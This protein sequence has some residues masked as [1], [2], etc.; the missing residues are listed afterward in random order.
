MQ[1][2][3]RA[4]RQLA[5]AQRANWSLRGV[6]QPSRSES[7]GR[8]AAVA[9]CQPTVAR[10]QPTVAR[11]ANW[12]SHNE[13]IGRCAVP[14]GRRAAL[15]STGRHA[16]HQLVVALCQPTVA[17]RANW[18]SHSESIGRCTVPAG[19]RAAR[20]LALT[21]RANWSLRGVN[22]PSRSGAIGRCAVPT[23][24]RAARQR[25]KWPS[26][27]VPIGLCVVS[28]GRRTARQLA[29]AQRINWSLRGVNRPSRGAAR[30]LGVTQ[31]TN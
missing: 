30:Q 16:A 23:G 12:L 10:C 29:V 19:R 15:E 20:Q 6:N 26:R 4:A 7:I 3:R 27:S 13:S 17:R 21:Q 11:R 8:C 22:R 25:L 5:L 28:T 18:L 2:G 1:A 14:P 24:R 9:R 31:C